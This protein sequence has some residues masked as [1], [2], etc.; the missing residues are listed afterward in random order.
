VTPKLTAIPVDP[1][2]DV[3]RIIGMEDGDLCKLIGPGYG[4]VHAP[5]C[6]W[7]K[8]RTDFKNLGAAEMKFEPCVWG[9]YNKT[10]ELVGLLMSHVDDFVFAGNPHEE[11][12]ASFLQQSKKLYYW[13]F[14]ETNN[15]TQCGV[16]IS[17][18]S[19]GGFMLKQTDKIKKVKE[20]SLDNGRRKVS[21]RPLTPTEV[22]RIRGVCSECQW[23]G[24]Q[25]VP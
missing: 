8:V 19:D 10:G 11:A 20:I 5:R 18:M 13:V 4:T 21:P 2:K 6:W 14:W 23:Y 12:W 22:T 15:I 16:Q 24:T 17:E 9:I 25:T 1:P 3:K 7:Q